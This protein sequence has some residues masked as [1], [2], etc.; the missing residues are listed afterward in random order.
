[1]VTA[2][3]VESNSV[4]RQPSEIIGLRAV[5]VH[6]NEYIDRFFFWCDEMG[7]SQ[8]GQRQDLSK[9]MWPRADY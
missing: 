5:C 7:I 4:V 6:Q 2:N 1:M 3:F 8:Y 9:L